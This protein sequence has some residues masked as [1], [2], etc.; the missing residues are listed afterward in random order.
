MKKII[1]R[2]IFIGSTVLAGTALALLPQGGK[3]SIRVEPFKV[4]EAVQEVLFPKGLKAPSASEFGATSYLATVSTHSSF[5]R[6][7][8]KFLSHGAT[9]LMDEEKNFLTMNPN[10]R[11]KALRNFV[12]SS[13]KAENWVALILFY[14]LEALLSDP[15]YG[16]NR[17]ESGWRW[18][19]H[20]TGKPQP[21]VRF[22]QLQTETAHIKE[23]YEK[24]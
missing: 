16:G 9:L 20:H 1:T 15:I 14:T 2:R 23:H 13:S 12:S 21:K 24:V 11:D 7:D 22:A 8:L 19:N 6:D 18:L 10:S 17:N 3:T 5:W 4:I